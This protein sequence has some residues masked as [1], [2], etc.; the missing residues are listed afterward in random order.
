[1]DALHLILYILHMLAM[2]AIIVAPFVAGHVHVIQTWGARIQLLVGLGL[3][4]L[5]EAGDDPVNH[6][7]IGTK[8]VI[9]IAVLACA[10]IGNGK[11]KRGENGKTLALVAAGLAVVNALVAFLW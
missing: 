11:S 1:M 9:M 6:A 2:L 3:T 8:L 5:A 4:G 7:K 10:E